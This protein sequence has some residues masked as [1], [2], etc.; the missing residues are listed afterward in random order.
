MAVPKHK[1]SKMRSRR[2][3]SANMVQT[4]PNLVACSNCGNKILLHHACP[5][6]GFYRNNEVFKPEKMA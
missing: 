6:C 5:K 3:R 2:R 4:A 1:T